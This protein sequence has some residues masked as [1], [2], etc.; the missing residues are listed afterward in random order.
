MVGDI[1][2]DLPKRR[3]RVM[4][5]S[6]WEGKKGYQLVE[7]E[8]PKAEMTDYTISLRAMTGGKGT[9]TFYFVRYEEVPAA[10]AT[11]I[12]AEAKAAAE[13]EK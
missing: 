13:A 3:G 10:E 8:V 12:I 2:G 6:A 9:Y 4:G 7:A 5:M 1:T 11:K